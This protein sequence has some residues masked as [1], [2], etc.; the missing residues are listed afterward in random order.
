MLAAA[1]MARLIILAGSVN[2]F[3][4]GFKFLPIRQ[5]KLLHMF[6]ANMLAPLKSRIVE[7]IIRWDFYCRVCLLKSLRLMVLQLGC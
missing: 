2:A 7:R 4:Y 3:L 5:A 6:G 1:Q